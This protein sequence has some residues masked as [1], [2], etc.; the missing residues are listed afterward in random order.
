MDSEDELFKK[1]Q[2]ERT[3]AFLNEKNA[4]NSGAPPARI[5][6]VRTPACQCR[7]IRPKDDYPRVVL[8]L[9]TKNQRDNDQ[10]KMGERQISRAQTTHEEGLLC[11]NLKSNSE[12]KRETAVTSLAGASLE[13][14]IA[15]AL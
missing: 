11:C 7:G 5:F 13:K 3:S 9:V 14:E 2:K 4:K 1:S 6:L 10:L 15:N 12:K 8:G